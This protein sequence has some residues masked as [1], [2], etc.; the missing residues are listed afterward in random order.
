MGDVHLQIHIRDLQT[1]ESGACL[2]RYAGCA[3]CGSDVTDR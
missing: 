3:E 1:E 2:F